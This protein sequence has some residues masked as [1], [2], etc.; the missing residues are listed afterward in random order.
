VV[1]PIRIL[2]VLIVALA[3]AFLA[4][5][6]GSD[7]GGSG[8]SNKTAGAAGTDGKASE[9]IPADSLFFASVNVDQGSDAWKKLVEVGARFPGWAEVATQ[10]QTSLNETSEDGVSWATD[11]QPWLGS[12]VGIAVTSL[13]LSNPSSPEPVV[14]GY[15][16]SK[17]DAKAA[18]L[19]QKADDVK[20]LAD[21]KGYKRWASGP[22]GFAAIGK[23]AVLVS[24]TEAALNQAIDTREGAGQKLADSQTF[25]DTLKQLPEDNL[26]VLYLDGPK[27]AQLATLGVQS[28]G[29]PA[30]GGGDEAAA[31]A[32]QQQITALLDQLRV[33][34][35]VGMSFGADDGGFRFRAATLMDE[36]RAKALGI[37]QPDFKPTL[38]DRTPASALAYFG[39]QNLGPMLKQ[40]LDQFSGD[41]PQVAQALTAFEA[42]TGVKFDSELVPLLSGEHALYVAPGAP[43]PIPSVGLLLKPEDAAA[44]AATIKKLTGALVNELGASGDDSITVEDIPNGQRFSGQQ[45]SGITVLWRQATD[46]IAFSNDPTAGDEPAQGL[47]DADKWKRLKD[48][49]G[50]GD[51]VSGLAYVDIPG[52]L[53]A[54]RAAGAGEELDSDPKVAANLKPLGGL[55]MFGDTK[56]GG[57]ATA[58]VYL[59]VVAAG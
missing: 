43:G 31:A 54:V 3:S 52:I 15:A 4:A 33:L 37:T 14:V 38:I 24:S 5:C 9:A 27:L 34:K 53:E 2:C 25:K 10:F 55:A 50:V 40:A 51:D 39:F 21:Y 29:L 44:G 11:I 19:V 32:Q 13:D 42:M 17:D 23:K 36:A 30:A 49:A 12:E 46:V 16:E 57:V 56:D 35:G 1:K 7:D 58:D 28:S 6:G 22:D 20:P 45:L 47:A 26:G 59:E 18:A 8:G 41:S 48:A